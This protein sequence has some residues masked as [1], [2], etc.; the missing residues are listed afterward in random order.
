[1]DVQIIAAIITGCA[2]IFAA[3]I[4]GVFTL[5]KRRSNTRSI[6]ISNNDSLKIRGTSIEGDVNIED[7]KNMEISKGKINGK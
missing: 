7:N 3:I 5:K 6:R 4:T 2:A 1:M